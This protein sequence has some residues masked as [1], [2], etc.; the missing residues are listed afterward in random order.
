MQIIN[1]QNLAKEDT[2]SIGDL[3]RLIG[4]GEGTVNRVSH[5]RPE[6]R[7]GTVESLGY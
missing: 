7:A 3:M 5:A 6:C 1:R 2:R 4:R